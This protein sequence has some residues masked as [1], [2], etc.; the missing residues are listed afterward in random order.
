MNQPWKSL[1]GA[2]LRILNG[3]LHKIETYR[4]AQDFFGP[5]NGTSDNEGHFGAKKSRDFHGEES[6]DVWNL[7]HP[8]GMFEMYNIP[9]RCCK[10]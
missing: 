6:R 10:F 9:P 1:N 2:I 3:P 8:A 5:L 4:G 7:Q